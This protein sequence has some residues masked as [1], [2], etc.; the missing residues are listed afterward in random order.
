MVVSKMNALRW[1]SRNTRGY[2]RSARA[3][4]PALFLL[5]AGLV[6]STVFPAEGSADR[7]SDNLSAVLL[8]LAVH[9]P[10]E[11]EGA[12]LRLRAYIASILNDAGA[13]AET[14]ASLAAF[15]ETGASL[16]GKQA[17]CRALRLIGSDI[18]LPVLSEMLSRAET[19]DMA[20][21]A[22]ESIPGN[23]ADEALLSALE[24]CEGDLKLGV[25]SSLGAR[26]SKA[27]VPVL[28]RI[29]RTGDSDAA[30]AAIEALGLIGD[31]GAAD[32]LRNTLG[33]SGGE[34]KAAAGAA[35][36]ACAD[37]FLRAGSPSEAA[38]IYN[39]LFLEN[40]SPALRAA[41]FQGKAA[42]FPGDAPKLIRDTLA[43]P[44]TSLHADA[45]SLIPRLFD[46]E[47][48][49][50]ILPL[51]EN[52]SEEG[53]IP[54]IAA[55]SN[56]PSSAVLAAVLHAA[57]DPSIGVRIEALKTLEAVGDASTVLFLAERAA[58][59]RG[60]EQTA[61]RESL[62]RLRGEESESALFDLIGR[63]EDEKI[64]GEIILA[65]G[66]RRLEGAKETLVRIAAT[67]PSAVRLQAARALKHIA[68]PADMDV[69]LDLML[70]SDDAAVREEL[71]TT[72]SLVSRV[73]PRP[74]MRSSL[75]RTR[76]NNET[77]RDR[78]ASLYRLLGRIGDDAS[79]P[80]VRK[81]LADPNPAAAEAAARTMF[82]W[83]S[84]AARDDVLELARTSSSLTLRVLA[85]RAFVRM[86]S[87]EPHRAPKGAVSDLTEA[88]SL[89]ERPEEK[90]LV[91]GAL[92]HFPCAEALDLAASLLEDDTVRAEALAA[93]DRIRERMRIP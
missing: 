3:A 38:G 35:L 49:G 79:L 86:I 71:L 44:D 70:S 46:A 2:L 7:N 63:V 82:D 64:L 61:A 85:I 88:F 89:C 24:T 31:A 52:L 47:T 17:V 41:A 5:T 72:I 11:G 6:F 65:A 34:L 91:L 28:A 26:K 48:V 9:D 10:A 55:L 69:L 50:P 33:T 25:I 15:L 84:P 60:A 78:R 56:F 90:R 22:L 58:A 36:L 20:R 54:F 23:K 21:Y 83:P 93:I 76:L 42:A 43:S 18:S 1:N 30:A 39:S 13:R 75:I 45:A 40:I 8:D 74:G 68:S 12:P 92:P 32:A 53:R 19:S 57:G 27:A 81:A 14:E 51:F 80:I 87:L 29:A 37:G 67:A 4:A 62:W 16:S 77:D 73:I 66:E 59:T